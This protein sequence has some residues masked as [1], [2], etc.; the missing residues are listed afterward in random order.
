VVAHAIDPA[1][2][3]VETEEHSSKP[4]RAV[5]AQDP[6]WKSLKCQSKQE[7]L[8][9][10][11]SYTHTH[12]HTRKKRALVD[13]SQP[14]ETNF[15]SQST[16]VKKMKQ[17]QSQRSGSGAVGHLK[18]PS[19]CIWSPR[20]REREQDSRSIWRHNGA[21]FPKQGMTSKH[22]CEKFREP[23]RNKLMKRRE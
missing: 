18:G 16:R 8:S 2:Q 14:R 11:P 13:T 5:S 21:I 23:A 7:A 20:R 4:V 22:R 3:E 19:M 15:I 6:I 17:K 12:T 10:V 1:S 9:S